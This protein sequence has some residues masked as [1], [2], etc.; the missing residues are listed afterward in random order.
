MLKAVKSKIK[1]SISEEIAK[2]WSEHVKKLVLQGEFLQILK[3]QEDSITWHSIIFN[4]PRKILQ[5]AA[6]ATINTLP[7]NSN[8]KR[9]GKRINDKCQMCDSKETLLH[10]LNNC[11]QKLDRYT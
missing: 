1:M 5:F 11:P 2:H 3:I 4:L 9:W 8:L 7:T 6:N 10:V